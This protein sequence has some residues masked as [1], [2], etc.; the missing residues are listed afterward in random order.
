[1]SKGGTMRKFAIELGL[2]IIPVSMSKVVK[3]HEVHP[4]ELH[5]GCGGRMG[6][7][8]YCKICGKQDIDKAD[9]IKGFEVEK[10]KYVEF[11][12]QD[13]EN[14]PIESL[15]TVKIDR[16]VSIDEI[17]QQNMFES[18]YN[19]T[20]GELG[21][22]PYQLLAEKMI[23]HN[24]VG[25][26]KVTL[27]N[28]EQLVAL[29]AKEEDGILGIIMST[30]YYADEIRPM[31]GLAKSQRV[32]ATT[33]ERNLLGQLMNKMT[34]HF[35]HKSYHDTYQ[36]ALK[37]AIETKKAGGTLQ[38]IPAKQVQKLSLEDALN[39]MLDEPKEEQD[40]KAKKNGKEKAT[41]K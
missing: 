20:P 4:N 16:F 14:I 40:R 18:P 7:K 22:K 3:E 30:M 35:D 9:I 27:S 8:N 39:S 32:E 34:K 29:K 26:G 1:M 36:E 15:K 19:L 12:E 31:L 38:G 37:L 24:K 6:R 11:T 25:I 10:D 17:D 2:I 23:E 41:T 21:V 5:Q 13:F 33:N 28:K